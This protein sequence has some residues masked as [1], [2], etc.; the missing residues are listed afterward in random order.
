MVYVCTFAD[1]KSRSW[2]NIYSLKHT[3]L[4]QKTTW[5]NSEP[6]HAKK[7]QPRFLCAFALGVADPEPTKNPK[8]IPLILKSW[9]F[10][11]ESAPNHQQIPTSLRTFISKA[12]RSA[13]NLACFSSWGHGTCKTKTQS[14]QVVATTN[15]QQ[16]VNNICHWFQEPI[17]LLEVPTMYFWPIFQ[18]DVREYPSKILHHMVQYLHFRILKF[19][20]NMSG[21]QNCSLPANGHG[22]VGGAL[23]VVHVFVQIWP[24]HESHVHSPLL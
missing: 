9:I 13:A 17:N 6:S 15:L 12:S 21:E 10:H 1:T 24:S 4:L 7:R 14:V 20:L 11:W 16:I 18:A 19:P 2:K 23:S 5:R 22:K 8:A 3:F